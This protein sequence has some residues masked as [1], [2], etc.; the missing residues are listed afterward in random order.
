MVMM[1]CYSVGHTI[2][3]FS[4][5]NKC[6]QKVYFICQGP[7]GFRCPVSEKREP[8]NTEQG[9]MNVEGKNFIIRNSLFEIQ[10]RDG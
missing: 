8:Q 10:N 1:N 2:S 6:G 5:G 9:I 7:I 3:H 4:R